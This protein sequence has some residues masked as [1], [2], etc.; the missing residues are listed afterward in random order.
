VHYVGNQATRARDH[1]YGLREA[2]PDLVGFALFD[3]LTTPLQ[4]GQPLR[5]RMWTRREIE[6]YLCSPEVLVS[7]AEASASTQG[8]GPLFA[9]AWAEAMRESI[10][11]VEHAMQT[12]G[13][14]TPWSPDTKVSDDFLA[15]L[16]ASF[17]SRLGL[18]NLMQKSDFHVLAHHV[19]TAQIDPELIRV[20]DEI[21]E[22]AASAKVVPG[23]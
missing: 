2:K 5:E 10:R 18:P 8:D 20:L 22:T 9:S 6:N 19:S 1:F 4:G 15:P 21:A 14:G 3:R 17:Y 12:L 16:F 13:K 23:E 11:D 7:W